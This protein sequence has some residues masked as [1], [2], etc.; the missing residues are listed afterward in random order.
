MNTEALGYKAYK[1]PKCLWVHAAIPLANAQEQVQIVNAW[2]ASK[3][4]PQTETIQRYLR[5][6]RCG[7]P[8][9]DFVPAL[10]DD[11][12]TGSTIQGVVVPGAW[13]FPEHSLV[14]L[15]RALPRLGLK[16]GATGVI[17]HVYDDGNAYEVE[18]VSVDGKTIGVFTVEPADL[19]PAESRP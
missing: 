11:A 18:F 17:V 6:F 8:T 12:P 4:E 7:A 5:C 15:K 16:S 2:H 3:G 9:A 1:C 19:L 14:V 10:S 13:S